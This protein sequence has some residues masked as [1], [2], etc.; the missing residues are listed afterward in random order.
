MSEHES[1]DQYANWSLSE[2]VVILFKHKWKIMA[3]GFLG[4]V[5]AAVVFLRAEPR[6]YSEAKL[7]VPYV[8]DRNPV[9]ATVEATATSRANDAIINSE[10]EILK[11]WDLTFQTAQAVGYIGASG[12]AT[13]DEASSNLVHGIAKNIWVTTAKGM[14][15]ISVAY[16]DRD[17]HQ[18]TKFLQELLK[19]YR[20]KHL[21]V[22]RFPYALEVIT[23]RRDDVRRQLDRT[24]STLKTLKEQVQSVS[25]KESTTALNAAVAS[26]HEALNRAE[27]ERRGQQA[28]VESLE[29]WMAGNAVAT[30]P[31]AQHSRAEEYRSVVE[32]LTQLRERERS[33]LTVYPAESRVVKIPRKQISELEEQRRNLES[34]YPGIAGVSAVKENPDTQSLI[35]SEKARLEAL[36]AT[37]EVLK[38]QF[39]EL[40]EKRDR[41]ADLAPQI[42]RLELEKEVLEANYKNI[43]AS[44]GKAKDDKALDWSKISNIAT[45]QEPSPAVPLSNPVRS[46]V[47]PGLAVGGLLLGVG[48]ALLK[49]K[50]LDRTIK[51]V[52]ELEGRL[53]IPVLLSIPYFRTSGRQNSKA[54]ALENTAQAD[55]GSD[56]VRGAA[57]GVIDH[58]IRPF[59]EAIRDR[60]ILSFELRNLSHK[61]KLI[62]VTGFST[63]AGAST[64]AG[65]LAA[66]LSETGDG[67]VLLVD[68]NVRDGDVHPFFAGKAAPPLAS[69]LTPA[70]A[71]PHAE[72]NLYLATIAGSHRKHVPL[73]LKRFHSLMPSLKAADFE[74]VIFDMPPL[75]DTSPTLG[76]ASFMDKVLLVIEAERSEEENIRRSYSDLIDSRANVSCVFNK[77]RCYIPQWLGGRAPH[78]S[79]A[80]SEQTMRTN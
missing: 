78:T 28:R 67:K 34:R 75:D 68:M 7:F 77:A 59:C 39:L 57:L 15:V 13:D 31:A 80:H 30:E 40:E 42:A 51:S 54:L 56:G 18:A 23:Q 55:P 3:C 8:V 60:M 37:E 65:G 48:I 12:G 26:G 21:N 22:H 76:M 19:H 2:I 9:D 46:K 44:L 47:A 73:G 14:N 27:A 20:E 53:R 45:V 52:P 62:G 10:V 66:A 32:L 16:S 70:G 29:Q 41:F 4:V 5:A 63:G 50:M 64:L 79:V 6:Y 74:Y 61:P 33:L 17:A 35:L 25:L 72:D 38:A 58:F 43:E 49:E 71:V 69:L 36:K 1:E 24:E 11:S